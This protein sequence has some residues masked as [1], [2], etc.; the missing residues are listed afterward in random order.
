MMAIYKHC[1]YLKSN[2]QLSACVEDC[3]YVRLCVC[4]CVTE[5]QLML[6]TQ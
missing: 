2:Y 6:E 4:V 3:A 5:Y 1:I